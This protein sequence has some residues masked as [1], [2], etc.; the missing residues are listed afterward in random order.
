MSRLQKRFVVGINIALLAVFLDVS[1]LIFIRTVNGMGVIQTSEMKWLT[2]LIWAL[3]YAF[4][5]MCQGL[6]YLLL[7]S[8]VAFKSQ[9]KSE[10][11][12]KRYA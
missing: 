4:I 3:C 1:M 6:A 12:H 7:K 11:K 10:H 8:L 9:Q 2:F 5:L